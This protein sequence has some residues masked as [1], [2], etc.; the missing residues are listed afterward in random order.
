[1]AI[2][3]REG[4]PSPYQVYWNNQFTGKRKSASFATEEQAKKEESLIKHRLKFDR[5]SFR[6]EEEEESD[7]PESSEL[8][9]GDVY[10]LYLKDRQFDAKAIV[11]NKHSA[12]RAL[13]YFKA[14]LDTLLK[15]D[16]TSGSIHK[17]FCIVKKV[18]NL[19][20]EQEYCEQVVF[21]KLPTLKYE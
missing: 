6:K 21:P 1:M 2:R 12:K 5:D 19:A 9:F 11:R 14:F 7:T 3:Y 16:L 4:R 18:L 10:L 13:E 20:I 17:Y 8:T 15:S